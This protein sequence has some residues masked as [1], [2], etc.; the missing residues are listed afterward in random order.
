MDAEA[1]RE[2]IF[3]HAYLLSLVHTI[4]RFSWFYLYSYKLE[5]ISHT[6]AVLALQV[7]LDTIHL[8]TW[9]IQRNKDSFQLLFHRVVTT[10]SE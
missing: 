5:R 9:S 10:L 2:W 3:I 6:Q 8:A 1:L 7:L 4:I